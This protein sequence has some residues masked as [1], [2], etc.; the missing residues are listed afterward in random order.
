LELSSYAEGNLNHGL[1]PCD[2]PGEERK[3][4]ELHRGES[5]T[6]TTTRTRSQ[7]YEPVQLFQPFQVVPTWRC[8]TSAKRYQTLSKEAIWAIP[9][10]AGE[11]AS[12]VSH[13]ADSHAFRDYSVLTNLKSLTIYE[14]SPTISFC[15]GPINHI[16]SS[17]EQVSCPV[18]LRLLK[19]SELCSNVLPMVY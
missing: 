6:Q 7:T 18:E 10:P 4:L 8:D 11:W 1:K 12:W 16:V 17:F 13:P 2:I 5:R 3:V 14:R 19:Y 15:T 9:I